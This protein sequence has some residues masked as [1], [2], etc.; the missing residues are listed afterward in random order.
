[1]ALDH[2]PDS[3]EVLDLVALDLQIGYLDLSCLENVDPIEVADP[4]DFG[5]FDHEDSDLD[6][7]CLAASEV[8]VEVPAEDLEV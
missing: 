8:L 1:M 7:R 2:L 5:L 6:F 3:L 4:V